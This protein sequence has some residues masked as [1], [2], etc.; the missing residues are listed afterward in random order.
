MT[1]R[2]ISISML[3]TGL[4]LAMVSDAIGVT[5]RDEAVALVQVAAKR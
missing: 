3:S 5:G 2:G 1:F 4:C